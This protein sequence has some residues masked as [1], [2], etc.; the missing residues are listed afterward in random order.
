MIFLN[1]FSFLARRR[2][3]TT[4]FINNTCSI[5][6]IPFGNFS[7]QNFHQDTIE[8]LL[9]LSI[10]KE[11]SRTIPPVQSDISRR[12]V[13]MFR[14]VPT[15]TE[16][17]FSGDMCFFDRFSPTHTLLCRAF[18]KKFLTLDMKGIC[19]NCFHDML[20]AVI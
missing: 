3:Y 18:H 2:N 6:I 20:D 17:I 5:S 8:S 15:K 12:D 9:L 19:R 16:N 10:R 7:V 4:K 11:K 14:E 1:N 13:L